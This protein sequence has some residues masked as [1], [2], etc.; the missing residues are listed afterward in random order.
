MVD[1]GEEGLAV[2]PDEADGEGC[3]GKHNLGTTGKMELLRVGTQVEL[4]LLGMGDETEDGMVGHDDGTE[5]KIV[6]GDG[7]DDEAAAIGREDGAAT[8]E[9]V[10]GG[11][12]GGGDDEAVGGIG[13]D[14]VVV[15]IE[16]GAQQRSIVETVETYLIERRRTVAGDI[17]GSCE[18]Y[19]QKG[20]GLEGVASAKD[21]VDEG[22][23][24][25]ASGGGEEA[26]MAKVDA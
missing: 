3:A 12:G 2:E 11:A 20:A 15:D 19:L 13:G 1:G 10:G 23:D 25:V 18:G 16:V 21:V 24:V 6:G 8:A 14:K 7:G 26:E 9:R 17:L 5:G 22:V 4:L